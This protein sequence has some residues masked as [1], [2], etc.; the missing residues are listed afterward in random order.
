V[1]PIELF[2]SRSN[3]IYLPI[4]TKKAE[5]LSLAVTVLRFVT[6]FFKCNETKT[7]WTPSLCF[8][9]PAD[10]SRWVFGLLKRQIIYS[11]SHFF[12]VLGSPFFYRAQCLLNKSNSILPFST[13]ICLFC[14][15]NFFLRVFLGRSFLF[16]QFFL[17]NILLIVTWN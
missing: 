5:F 12:S 7:R 17:I 4:E 16:R 14:G 2:M 1:E 6:F 13:K 9:S 11:H 10:D 3:L 15:L 8:E